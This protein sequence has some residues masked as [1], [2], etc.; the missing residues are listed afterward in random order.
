MPFSQFLGSVHFPSLR[1]HNTATAFFG[2]L[3][4][5]WITKAALV[6]AQHTPHEALSLI[7]GMDSSY[8]RPYMNLLEHRYHGP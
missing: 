6:F 4:P 2:F 5:G 8:G 1:H 3:A 7:P